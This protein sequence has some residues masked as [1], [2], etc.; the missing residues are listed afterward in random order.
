LQHDE[1]DEI[2]EAGKQSKS[3]R[4]YNPGKEGGFCFQYKRKFLQVL[5]NDKT[6]LEK[7]GSGGSC[8]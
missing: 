4:V 3:H 5:S 7:L 8:L 1:Q 6:S 2:I